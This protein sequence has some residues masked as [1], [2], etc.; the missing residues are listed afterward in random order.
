MTTMEQLVTG[1][2]HEINTPLG[3]NV[4][5]VSHLT[6]LL[7]EVDSKMEDGSLSKNYFKSFVDD[8][9]SL[10]KL[11]SSNLQKISSLIQR[12]KLVSVNQVDIEKANLNFKEQVEDVIEYYF[13]Q[14]TKGDS[15]NITVDVH[16]N[17]HV[18]IHSYPAAWRVILDQLFENSIVHG[19]TKDQMLKKISIQLNCL[20]GV[21]IVSYEDN[22]QGISD[23]MAERVF[24]PFVTSKR[25]NAENAGLGMY[26]VY[27]IV[28]QVLKGDIKI[29]KAK[30]FKAVIRFK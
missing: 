6:E 22:G 11:M 30:G 3:N 25:G 20:D 2:A 9:R 23:E 12:F 4:T 13:F 14:H 18:M 24:D 19:F 15:N 5:S 1:V 16:T 28:N 7:T 26:R 21:W 29:E 10:M 8:S 27:N 17:G